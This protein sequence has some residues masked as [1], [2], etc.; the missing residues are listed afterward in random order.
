MLRNRKRI[1]LVGKAGA[2][3][4]YFRDFLFLE[5]FNVDVS[6]TTRPPRD[7]EKSG[8]TYNYVSTEEF[9]KVEMYEG[10]EFNGWKYGTSMDSWVKNQV[11]VVTP[12]G[13]SQYTKEDRKNSLVIYF[14]IEEIIRRRRLEKRSDCDS[15]ERRIK[16]DEIDF[17]D[18]TD[19]NIH[20]KDPLFNC[21]ELIAIINTQI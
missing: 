13:L 20:V 6:Y 18:F 8:Y 11:F 15:V 3:K 7:G 17:K 12:S 2:G 5:G 19:F 10:V 21:E 4:D 14:D 9:N 1:V 16:S